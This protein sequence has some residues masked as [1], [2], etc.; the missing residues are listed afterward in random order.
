MRTSAVA[1]QKL[2][3]FRQRRAFD[4][5][6][7]S[8]IFQLS[9]PPPPEAVG[10]HV[11]PGRSCFQLHPWAAWVPRMVPSHTLVP[12][13]CPTCGHGRD[14]HPESAKWRR[15]PAIVWGGPTG[16]WF[17]DC[18]V[19]VSATTGCGTKIQT[20]KAHDHLVRDLA[21]TPPHPPAPST[22]LSADSPA[23]SH[24]STC[25]STSYSATVMRLIL[26]WRIRCSCGG[27][28]AKLPRP[29][30]AQSTHFSR[31]DSS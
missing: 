6:P 4:A 22:F 13:P 23:S 19:H 15:R 28:P 16:H 8:A 20:R 25:A 7:P 12:P 17:L 31:A 24:S 5:N 9:L 27:E 14:V 21:D 26:T 2:W 18:K 30:P 3:I 11:Q 1:V 29:S 10:L